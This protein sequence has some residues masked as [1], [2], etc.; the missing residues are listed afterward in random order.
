LG[1]G[2][3]STAFGS[4][5]IFLQYADK[6]APRS[7]LYIVH[8]LHGSRDMNAYFSQHSDDKGR[9]RLNE[10]NTPDYLAQRPWTI[11]P[12]DRETLAWRG[13]RHDASKTK[14]GLILKDLYEDH[15]DAGRLK[16]YAPT[17]WATLAVKR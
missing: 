12:S 10:E 17:Y 9:F 16:D 6:G 5:V 13:F 3:R 7:H 1:A 11:L 14:A 4:Y 8:V 2:F 15:N